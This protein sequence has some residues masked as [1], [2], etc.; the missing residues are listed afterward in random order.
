MG[1]SAATASTPDALIT[2]AAAVIG[3]AL[4]ASAGGVGLELCRRRSREA[5]VYL[6][7][8]SLSK[9]KQCSASSV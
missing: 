5:A 2:S 4:G 6:Q 7:T 8:R 3:A 1:R 9:T